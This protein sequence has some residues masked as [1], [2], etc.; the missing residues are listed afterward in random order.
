MLSRCAPASHDCCKSRSAALPHR[1]RLAQCPPDGLLYRDSL[2]RLPYRVSRRRFRELRHHTGRSV[3]RPA[4]DALEPKCGSN[5]RVSTLT[6][7]A[8]LPWP[9]E[10]DSLPRNPGV[11]CFE[12]RCPLVLGQARPPGL[13]SSS[14]GVQNELGSRPLPKR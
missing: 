1:V 3:L 9:A 6:L 14:P 2:G 12:P 10:A 7:K 5:R 4:A 13:R 11:T 8:V